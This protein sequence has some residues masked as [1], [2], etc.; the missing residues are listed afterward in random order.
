[1][2]ENKD[3]D[4]GQYFLSAK[5]KGKQLNPAV[6][7]QAFSNIKKSDPTANMSFSEEDFRKYSEEL[8]EDD[9]NQMKSFYTEMMELASVAEQQDIIAPIAV[10]NFRNDAEGINNFSSLAN[11]DLKVDPVYRHNSFYKPFQYK[12]FQEAAEAN[13]QYFDKDGQIKKLKESETYDD[14]A[15]PWKVGFGGKSLVVANNEFVARHDEQLAAMIEAGEVDPN[16]HYRDGEGNYIYRELEEG[17]QNFEHVRSIFG[18]RTVY[19]GGFLKESAKGFY[20]GLLGLVDGVGTV[21]YYLNLPGAKAL[22]MLGIKDYEEAQEAW[23][24]DFMATTARLKSSGSMQEDRGLFDNAANFSKAVFNGVGQ[25]VGT[26]G[27]GYALGGGLK[28]VGALA[29]ANRVGKLA[30][31]IAGDVA[32]GTTRVLNFGIAAKAG[33]EESMRH[34]LT[35]N[36]SDF[37]GMIA[38]SIMLA[39][40][41]M[42][43]SQFIP[44]MAGREGYK[45]T[46]RKVSEYFINEAERQGLKVT[47]L[48]QNP[49]KFKDAVMKAHKWLEATPTTRP[50]GFAQGFVGEAIQ[51][52]SEDLLFSLVQDGYDLIDGNRKFDN[53]WNHVVKDLM[54]SFAVGGIS[55]GLTRFGM[56]RPNKAKRDIVD[57]K[58][59]SFIVN[60]VAQGNEENLYKAIDDVFMK[61]GLGS[62]VL[63]ANRDENGAKKLLS[64][65]K[66]LNNRSENEFFRDVFKA[67][68]DLA[69]QVRNQVAEGLPSQQAIADK[70][71]EAMGQKVTETGISMDELTR[72]ASMVMEIEGMAAMRNKTLLQGEMALMMARS[73]S[74][75]GVPTLDDLTE[76]RMFNGK[77]IAVKRNNEADFSQASIE[78]QTALELAFRDMTSDTRSDFRAQFDPLT[79]ELLE[80]IKV[81]NEIKLETDRYNDN[82]RTKEFALKR[83]EELKEAEANEKKISDQIEELLQKEGYNPEI[84]E[85]AVQ[86]LIVDEFMESLENGDRAERYARNFRLNQMKQS[87]PDVFRGRENYNIEDFEDDKKGFEYFMKNSKDL[88]TEELGQSAAFD[89]ELTALSGLGITGLSQ[90]NEL[91][92]GAIRNSVALSEKSI[93]RIMEYY[94]PILATVTKESEEKYISDRNT[95]AALLAATDPS[96]DGMFGNPFA[97]ALRVEGVAGAVDV[98]KNSEN[99]DALAGRIIGNLTADQVMERIRSI[100]GELTENFDES[101]I[102]E[103]LNAES[104]VADY[105][106]TQVFF[107]LSNESGKLLD[108]LVHAR[109]LGSD[110]ADVYSFGINQNGKFD[111]NYLPMDSIAE[112]LRR[113]KEAR[114]ADP[115]SFIDDGTLVSLEEEIRRNQRY[116]YARALELYQGAEELSPSEEGKI[117]YTLNELDK[118]INDIAELKRISELNRG[119]R[120]K[121]DYEVKRDYISS[122]TR[123]LKT[124][125]DMLGLEIGT[126]IAALDRNIPQGTPSEELRQMV[127]DD[128]KKLIE[129]EVE[130]SRAVQEL[131]EEDSK[132]LISEFVLD[133]IPIANKG[134]YLF[135]MFNGDQKNPF[136]PRNERDNAEQKFN[137]LT[138]LSRGNIREF[139][140]FTNE[141]LKERKPDSDL[142][143]S[144]EQIL[145]SR[146][147]FSKLNSD[148]KSNIENAVSSLINTD[149][150]RFDADVVFARGIAGAGKSTFVV[151]LA[152]EI[153]SRY[154]RAMGMPEGTTLITAP[155]QPQIDNISKSFD[156]MKFTTNYKTFVLEGFDN[157]Y[158]E[159]LDGSIL[160]GVDY[161]VVDEATVFG[162]TL[163]DLVNKANQ[164]KSRGS[165]KIKVVLVGDELQKSGSIEPVFYSKSGTFFAERTVPLTTPYRSG[166][167]ESFDMNQMHRS[168]IADIATFYM[169]VNYNIPFTMP[170]TG[171]TVQLDLNRHDYDYALAL[172]YANRILRHHVRGK[173]TS[174]FEKNGAIEEGIRAYNTAEEVNRKFVSDYIARENK[175]GMVM[176][177]EDKENTVAEI[178]R[179]FD[180][181]GEQITDAKIEEMVRTSAETQGLSYPHVYTNIQ[182]VL[183]E[184]VSDVMRSLQSL[185]VAESR[186][187]RSVVLVAPLSSM[188][189]KKVLSPDSIV[190]FSEL[191][192]DQKDEN[193]NLIDDSL[194]LFN[195]NEHIARVVADLAGKMPESRQVEITEQTVEE[196]LEEQEEELEE[197]EPEDN[198]VTEP[199]PQDEM[200]EEEKEVVNNEIEQNELNEDQIL[201]KIS[202]MTHEEIM[203]DDVDIMDMFK[204]C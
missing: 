111:A 53:D 127:D 3:I 54:G 108:R 89:S 46:S 148:K 166:K 61:E 110:T 84:A 48:A 28:A 160:K 176:I 124:I 91:V 100:E 21:G 162:R 182:L 128:F 135:K 63:S 197:S 1:M 116:L 138:M 180:S 134:V 113:K 131:S 68:V 36:E 139:F 95:V 150:E 120:F 190:K 189:S 17:E 15:N 133:H 156:E 43:G 136:D 119:D 12:T 165:R 157:Q 155:I 87:L 145:I 49:S 174:Y 170:D 13:M 60:E 178:R 122:A 149:K 106:D 34:G 7:A 191:N 52:T 79:K 96:L 175:E 72:Q 103:L 115:S 55:G 73:K 14:I 129:F 171:E 125:S 40:E 196:T 104:V 184:D 37:M 33:K 140:T 26:M 11:D 77:V 118:M 45:E 202:N 185:Y 152:F 169:Y 130:V 173:E 82:S 51:E 16:A 161:V 80:A 141:Y 192:F 102:Q 31:T 19:N 93:N 187:K 5:E 167:V 107:T 164:L 29:Q 18:P 85:K 92:D 22:S 172:N 44:K 41:Y 132:K 24:N 25:I 65:D 69:V 66:G 75:Q 154:Q 142:F 144:Q 98:L 94:Q 201:D 64:K 199:K 204:D 71:F 194:A 74:L 123:N 2:A 193:E 188:T 158:Q 59:N 50:M 8:G 70:M 109:R 198:T 58:R 42:T 126:E 143:P 35:K 86:S 39:T 117:G 67:Q 153:T 6:M 97:G 112:V 101:M 81:K 23:F 147:L 137:Y 62:K 27:T 88:I 30:G 20:D 78:E 195:N 168:A 38:G 146:H 99:S 57:E 47:Q 177:T 181:L 10:K 76:V 179:I 183:N 163:L 56:A 9:A 4:F 200:T 159:V 83:L 186:E 203:S 121:R 114:D 32:S 151:N 105:F 90:V